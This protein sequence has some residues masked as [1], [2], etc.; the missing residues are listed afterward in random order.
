[1]SQIILR[2]I[3]KKFYVKEKAHIF[4]K[5]NVKTIRALNNVSFTINEGEI[6]GYIGPNGAGKSTTV[7]VMSGIL[8]PDSGEC[9]I[10]G[11]TPWKN[12]VEHVANIGVI[13]GQRSQ[14]WW[15]VPV[16]DSFSLLKDI[17]NV[18]N[19]LFKSRQDELIEVLDI[20]EI[21][22]TPVRLLSLGQRM[23][24]EI[25]ASLLHR[26]KI[27]FL[28][29]PTIGLDA[30]SKLNLRKF[31]KKEN[32]HYGVTMILTTH[33]MDDIEALS[34]RV[35]VIGRGELLYD[36]SLTKLK[37][38]YAKLSCIYIEFEDVCD[39]IIINDAVK[40]D[41]LEN[42]CNIWFDSDVIK[43]FKMI[44]NLEERFNIKD[45]NVKEKSID[46][47]IAKMYKEL[48]I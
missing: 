14:L 48:S 45:A 42:G 41:R 39:D 2:N 35:M 21:I 43:P 13:F 46:E 1:M 37:E 6:I 23:R 34:S 10:L 12:R 24:C 25:A 19:N 17:Y 26:P 7:K 30:V 20:S 27:L 22:S 11:L 9:E 44:S 18:D 36:G 33:D 29:E 4:K 47:I 16:I 38:K 32:E 3:S 5:R 28:D 31:L 8:V 40:I 15:D